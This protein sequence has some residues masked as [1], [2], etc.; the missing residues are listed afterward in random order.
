MD[1]TRPS[2]WVHLHF[3]GALAGP[4]QDSPGLWAPLAPLSSPTLLSS[5]P[6]PVAPPSGPPGCVRCPAWV[7]GVRA[8]RLSTWEQGETWAPGGSRL[9]AQSPPAGPAYPGPRGSVHSSA[10]APGSP[11]AHPGDLVPVRQ[12]GCAPSPVPPGRCFGPACAVSER[13]HG[14]ELEG[15]TPHITPPRPSLWRP[16]LGPPTQPVPSR[17]HR[18]P[19]RAGR[20]WDSQGLSGARPAGG[21]LAP[22]PHHLCGPAP[23]PPPPGT[24]RSHPRVP[25]A[26]GHCCQRGNSPL[27]GSALRP[28]AGG[29]QLL[30]ECARGRGAGRGRALERDLL[31]TSHKGTPRR[32]CS[33]DHRT[34]ARRRAPLSPVRCE[35][36]S[37]PVPRFPCRPPA[38][39]TCATVGRPPAVRG[40]L[41]EPG[42]HPSIQRVGG[43]LKNA[44][45][46]PRARACPHFQE[47]SL[48]ALVGSQVASCSARA[49]TLKPR[50]S[51]YPQ[52]HSS[53]WQSRGQAG[54]GGAA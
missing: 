53:F 19:A 24:R 50:P 5:P 18:Q 23:C 26:S 30:Q 15:W 42:R 37:G 41:R 47:A 10:L 45:L 52:G 40:A 54:V 11:R 49:L 8:G 46:H 3:C 48:A 22:S 51:P 35:Q 17:R 20:R 6:A 33:T 36:R 4:S 32:R 25:G 16:W 44:F 2:S 29:T 9:A 27:P 39:A 38:P 13:R 1:G 43:W 21:H 14:G 7:G 31:R 34:G 12:A 28:P